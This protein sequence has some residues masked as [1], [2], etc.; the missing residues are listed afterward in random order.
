[1]K[2]NIDNFC[3]KIRVYVRDSC[4]CTDHDFKDSMQLDLMNYCLLLASAG[5][6]IS[7]QSARLLEIMFGHHLTEREW[8]A[9]MR[10]RALIAEEYMS[11]VP[12]TFVQVIKAENAMRT[13]AADYSPSAEYVEFFSKAATH[14][15]S[16]IYPLNNLTQKLQSQ[17]TNTL[18]TYAAKRLNY[19][20]CAAPQQIN[21][22]E[23]SSLQ[24]AVSPTTSSNLGYRDFCIGHG[25]KRKTVRVFSKIF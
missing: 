8:S 11:H 9:Y 18:K 3:N 17:Y 1:M 12:Y 13:D 16:S 24:Q 5:G 21:R 22:V 15:Q 7:Q 4:E 23:S 25:K 20:W 10:E 14:M 2:S 19:P 6:K